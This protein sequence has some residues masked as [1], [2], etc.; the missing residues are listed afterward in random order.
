MPKEI[1]RNVF[2][3]KKVK[4]IE[5]SNEKPNAD[6]VSGHLEAIG[7]NDYKQGIYESIIKRII[8]VILS[9]IGL[10]LLS[11]IC[12]GAG[13]EISFENGE[14]MAAYQFEKRYRVERIDIEDGKAVVNLKE[15][16]DANVNWVGSEEVSFF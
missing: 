6:G 14:A 5:D 8:D 10:I 12:R 15:I 13:E 1:D 4:F 16:P 7:D 9:L 3:G 11:V 2:E